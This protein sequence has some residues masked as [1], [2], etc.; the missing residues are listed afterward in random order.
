MTKI[1][2]NGA[3]VA[4][5]RVARPTNQLTEIERFY[6]SGLGLQKIGSFQGH[7]GYQG[8]MIGIPNA[9]YHLEIIQHES[10]QPVPSPTKEDLL[11][12]YIPQL[13]EILEIKNRLHGL[14]Y[15]SVLPENPYWE[16]KGFIFADPD[17]WGVILMNTSGI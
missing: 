5:V 14:G 9:S 12:F 8:I 10:G 3:A 17:G 16:E 15:H 6:C 7:S 13:S 4:Q 11:V 2:S 1:W